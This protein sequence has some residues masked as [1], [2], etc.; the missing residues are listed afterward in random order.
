MGSR[1]SGCYPAEW[2]STWF[3]SINCTPEPGERCCG[4]CGP[5]LLFLAAVVIKPTGA[6]NGTRVEQGGE[7]GWWQTQPPPHAHYGCFSCGDLDGFPPLLPLRSLD[8]S[9]KLPLVPYVVPRV[10]SVV[11]LVPCVVPLV[12]CA[13]PLVP[14]VVP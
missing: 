4:R 7:L 6:E 3:R 9:L 11:P 14:C 2:L 8:L 1:V 10:P 12:P 13:V 5:G